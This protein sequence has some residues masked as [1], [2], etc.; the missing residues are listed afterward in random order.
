MMS[1]HQK[2][3]INVA[4]A[5]CFLKGLDVFSIHGDSPFTAPFF[6]FLPFLR[7]RP[8]LGC[9]EFSKGSLEL[10]LYLPL[11]PPHTHTPSPRITGLCHHVQ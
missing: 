10:L 5:C 4:Q 1:A 2:L 11:P 6:C 8:I 3:F 7:Q 9:P